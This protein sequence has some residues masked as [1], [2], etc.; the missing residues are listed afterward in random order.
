MRVGVVG[1]NHKLAPLGLRELLARVCTQQFSIYDP[2]HLPHQFVL[3]S[4]CNRTEIYFHSDDLA[5]THTYILNL[6]KRDVSQELEQKLYSFFGP[7]CFH[8]LCRVTAG[9]DSA[10]LAET[11]IQG[12]VKKAYLRAT[13]QTHLP[14]EFHFL[15]QK[16]LQ[17][18]KK[19]RH[20][21]ALPTG[22]MNLEK[23]IYETGAKFFAEGG[24]GRLLLV[25][26]SEINGNI[27][28]YLRSK[29]LPSITL[30]NRSA[31]NGNH[32]A[33]KFGV[34]YLPWKQ[35]HEWNQ[36]DWII[37]G[38]ASPEP[39][40]LADH[41]RET[42]K[43]HLIFDLSVPRNVEPCIAKFPNISLWNIDQINARIHF[44]QQNQRKALIFAEKAVSDHTQSLVKSYLMKTAHADRSV[45]APELVMMS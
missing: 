18:G 7:C 9:L 31:E 30:C 15:F 34:A 11:E 14:S 20:T 3:L 36:F 16:A 27:L 23:M 1:V 8:H 22:E 39:I 4:T 38:T 24:F 44:T 19:V 12:Q 6:L 43:N 21:H 25:G 40:L 10:I 37:Y 35:R 2:M 32:L 26:A 41:I 17:A 33:E 29:N 28:N 5:L 13:S 42:T 45:A